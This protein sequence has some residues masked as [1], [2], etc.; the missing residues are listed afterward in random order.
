MV[1]NFGV[2]T[3]PSNWGVAGFSAG[4]TCA[5]DLTVMHPELFS[6]FVD[7]AGDLGLNTGTKAQTIARLFGG[8][9]DAWNAFDPITVITRH[10]PYRGLSG[11]FAIVG[12]DDVAANTLCA[13][14]ISK[15]I[16]CAV[17]PMQA[18]HDW[19]FAGR[20]FAAALPWLAGQLGTPGV[21]R[22]PFPNAPVPTTQAGPPP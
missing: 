8:S 6:A 15:G 13:L 9:P 19:A 20:A 11:W 3:E 22:I 18:K 12:G 14:G 4:G 10:S 2:S 7:I 1:S 21:P 16:A 5:I 17:V